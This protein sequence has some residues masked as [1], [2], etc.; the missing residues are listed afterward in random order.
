MGFPW[1]IGF[2]T[3]HQKAKKVFEFSDIL[4]GKNGNLLESENLKKT[5]EA[6]SRQDDKAL[7]G[8]WMVRAGGI[9]MS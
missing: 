9:S 5:V 3:G 7:V 2:T 1:S 4:D 8:F 6:R